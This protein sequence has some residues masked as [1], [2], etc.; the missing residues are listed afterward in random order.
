MKIQEIEIAFQNLQYR[1][2]DCIIALNT[3]LALNMCIPKFNKTPEANIF[4]CCQTALLMKSIINIKTILEPHNNKK[5]RIANLEYLVNEIHKNKEYFAQ[6]HFDNVLSEKITFFKCKD[7]KLFDEDITF[8]EKQEL[9]IEAKTKCL[10]EIEILKNQCEK[11]RNENQKH[12][13]LK[14]CRDSIAHSFNNINRDYISI[15]RLQE[16]LDEINKFT[17]TIYHIL[18]MNNIDAD[19]NT[20]INKIAQNFWR[21]IVSK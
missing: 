2:H 16:I 14:K 4:K 10:E 21:G 11:F 8:Q 15:N 17:N 1:K 5:D 19:I 7:S 9:A 18:Y 6:K 13:D 3:L 20:V 12:D